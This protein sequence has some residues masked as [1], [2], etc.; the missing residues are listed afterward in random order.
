MRESSTNHPPDAALLPPARRRLVLAVMM[1][2]V[3]MVMSAVSGLNVA[4]PDLARDTAAT[5]S[6]L[7]WIVDAYAL[8]F[9]GLLLP[10]GAL[11]DRFGR[12]GVLLVGLA[13]FG[14]SAAIVALF[15]EGPKELIV[16][17]AAMGAGAALVMPTTLSVITT[18]FPVEERG[19]AVG[20]WVGVAGGGAI[21]G[22]LGSGLLLEWFSWSSFFVLNVV[23]AVAAAAGTVA[24]VPRSRDPERP[25]LDP[26]G[27]L[28]SLTG[29]VTLVYAIIEAP[30][31]GWLDPVTLVLFTGALVTL[32]AFVKWELRIDQPMLDPRLF[33]LPGF[34]TGSLSLTVQFFAAFG[35][36]FIILQYLQFV[37]GLSPLTAAAVM[38]PM[39]L[40]MIPTAR[41]APMIAARFGANRAGAA[42]LSLIAA[43]L[44]ILSFMGTDFALPHFVAGL[45][46]FAAGMGLAGTPA[47][48]AIVSAVP[49]AKQGVVS[50]VNDTTRELGAA[51]GI[52]VLGSLL[53]DRYRSGVAALTEQLPAEMAERARESIAFVQQGVVEKMGPQGERLVAQA[54]QAFVDGTGAAL[55]AGA[56]MLLLAAVYVALRAPRARTGEAAG[57][58]AGED[59]RER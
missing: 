10:A 35:F 14:L 55:L 24:F 49:A 42:G 16:L 23:L 51:L 31:R 1:L 59:L 41:N 30:D 32:V 39:P 57:A 11:G 53:N 47:T 29:L 3:M 37:A 15:A 7:Q 45:V 38:L 52:A 4:L 12:K 58:A 28:L 46:V 20:L 27:G 2:A 9:A 13:I 56:A 5:Q 18:S 8:V 6:D 26:V 21:L 22:L 40:V 36:F 54:E 48:T 33:R 17:R 25:R 43:G 50:A 19:R 44:V 34:G